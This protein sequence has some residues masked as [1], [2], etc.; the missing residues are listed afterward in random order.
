[1]LVD[2]AAPE[3]RRLIGGADDV[4]FEDALI[5]IVR[6]ARSVGADRVLEPIRHKPLDPYRVKERAASRRLSRARPAPRAAP[7]ARV[8]G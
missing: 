4:S 1:M 8:P 6:L 3:V 5:V 2:T 7:R